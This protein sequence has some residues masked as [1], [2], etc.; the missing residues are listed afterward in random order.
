MSTQPST[1][2]WLTARGQAVMNPAKIL[3]IEDTKNIR[4]EIKA[5]LVFEGMEVCVAE[6]GEEGLEFA[7]T[8]KPD[9]ILCD[10]MM[11]IKNGYEVFDDAKNIPSL[12]NTPFIFLTARATTHNVREGMILGADDYI[13]KPFAIDLLIKSI[14][15]RLKKEATRKKEESKKRKDLQYSISSAI[16][17]ELITPLSGIIG[18]SE[19]LSE[20][21]IDHSAEEVR[22]YSKKI[23]ESG[24]RMLETINKFIYYTEVEILL[25][26]NQK[27]QGLIKECTD[28]GAT[29]LAGQCKI[30]ARKYNRLADLNMELE[31]FNA[32]ILS[33]HF[34]IIIS[35]IVDNAF[36]FSAP[37]DEVAVNVSKDEHFVC[38]SVQDQGTCNFNIE[39]I[40]AFLQF[41][42]E[43]MEQKG[44]GLGLITAL[45][46]VTFY[47][48]SVDFITSKTKGTQ[49]KLSFQRVD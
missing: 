47:H 44:L 34:E 7:K 40:D 19:L 13:T 45:K 22:T 16:P 14:N 28:M 31:E 36:K 48:G 26:D 23:T 29:V 25:Q 11:P 39:D 5:I 17:H 30:V 6:N 18:L 38:I 42:R 4:D 15:S 24:Y 49:V 41:N 8:F 32:K 9:L 27:R 35:N 3:I 10:I 21:D 2:Q 12:K 43:K 20:P 37:G 33:N 46:L 1:I